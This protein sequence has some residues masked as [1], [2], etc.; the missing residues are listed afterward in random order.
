MT[1]FHAALYAARINSRPIKQNT[2]IQNLD[3]QSY[4]NEVIAIPELQ[5][6]CTI[7]AYLDGETAK[8]DALVARVHDAIDRLKELRSALIPAAVTGKTDVRKAVP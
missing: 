7:G 4:L 2:G 3:S 8:I 5:E 6:Q 1:Y